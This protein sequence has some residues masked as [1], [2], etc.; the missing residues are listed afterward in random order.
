MAVNMYLK[1]S[2]ESDDCKKQEQLIKQ[3]IALS[4]DKREKILDIC[5]FLNSL[6]NPDILDFDAKTTILWENIIKVAALLRKK[7]P[8]T[9]NQLVEKACITS[10]EA[11]HCI[12]ILI[13]IGGEIEVKSRYGGRE[14]LFILHN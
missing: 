9:F 11:R 14:Q 8:L 4:S 12:R 3:M 10:S 7:P 5:D 2:L 13:D 6:N 1:Y